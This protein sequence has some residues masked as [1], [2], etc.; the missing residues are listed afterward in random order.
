MVDKEHVRR[1]KA[2]IV[3]E[4]KSMDCGSW[5][6]EEKGNHLSLGTIPRGDIEA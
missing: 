1:N 3:I 6:E 2:K 4:S 5:I